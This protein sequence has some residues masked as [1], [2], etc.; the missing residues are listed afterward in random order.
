MAKSPYIRRELGEALDV[1]KQ[2]RKLSI[3]HP[4]PGKMGFD[5]PSKI[6]MTISPSNLSLRGL[7]R[8][9]AL[10]K[11]W[12][13]RLWPA[14]CVGSAEPVVLRMERSLESINARGRVA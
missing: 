10:V 2:I 14:S 1:M 8:F 4:N 5:I 11:H 9:K 3:G 13:T 12:I 6:F 7:R